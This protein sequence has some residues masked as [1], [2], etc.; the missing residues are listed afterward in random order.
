[1]ETK[2]YT[3]CF[4]NSKRTKASDWAHPK[5]MAASGARGPSDFP[6]ALGCVL[7]NRQTRVVVPDDDPPMRLHRRRRL[8][9]AQA[10][11]R[12]AVVQWLVRSGLPEPFEQYGMVLTK[13]CSDDARPSDGGS[14]PNIPVLVAWLA[15][16]PHWASMPCK[17][18]EVNP[19]QARF[20]FKILMTVHTPAR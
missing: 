14:S 12:R 17:R 11:V 18:T 15:V 2:S 20:V 10:R 9:P 6:C 8:D 3:T 5:T 13:L 1:M 7:D 4:T 19:I 16:L